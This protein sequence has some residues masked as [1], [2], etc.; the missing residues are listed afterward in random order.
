LKAMIPY[1]GKYTGHNSCG[2]IAPTSGEFMRV[3]RL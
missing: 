1:K 3:M 2:E